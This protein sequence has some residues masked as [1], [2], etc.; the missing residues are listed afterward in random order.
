MNK[1]KESDHRVT[2]KE[3]PSKPLKRT[4]YRNA[5]PC[6]LKDFEERCAYS[7]IHLSKCGEFEVDH[8]DAARKKDKVQNYQ[9]LFPA[10]HICNRSKSNKPKKREL[11]EGKRFLNPCLEWDYNE[12]ICEN[13]D[14]HELIGKTKPGIYHIEHLD[15][16]HPLFVKQRKDRTDLLKIYREF[17]VRLKP[18]DADFE[19]LLELLNYLKSEISRAIPEIEIAS[20]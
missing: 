1:W 18:G 4:T 9:N 7:M 13:S 5:Y 6:L 17:S 20:K 11:R 16:N 19:Q 12:H 10:H 2:R 15:L 3:S 14:T 8:F